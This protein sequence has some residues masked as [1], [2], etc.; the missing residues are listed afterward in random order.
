[1]AKNWLDPAEIVRDTR[2]S[3]T[4]PENFISLVAY[5]GVY[6]AFVLVLTGVAAWDVLSTLRFDL[7]IV[8]GKRQWRW[9]MVILKHF[10]LLWLD[11]RMPRFSTLYVGLPCCCI[12]FQWQ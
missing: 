9:P 8:R 11:S 4:H 1:M 3:S 5:I 6:G 10:Y 7:S 12:Y 2:K